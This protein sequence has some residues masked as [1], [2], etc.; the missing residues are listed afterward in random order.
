MRK[1]T[2]LFKKSINKLAPKPKK[3]LQLLRLRQLYSGV[4]VKVNKATLNML[5]MIQPFVTYGFVN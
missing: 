2:F 4:F 1:T 5:Q 3:I